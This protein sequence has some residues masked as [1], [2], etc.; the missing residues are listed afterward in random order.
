MTGL[1]Q[2][3]LYLTRSSLLIVLPTFLVIGIGISVLSTTWVLTVLSTV[4]LGVMAIST[5]QAD[6]SSGWQ[7]FSGV[8][9][10]S[11]AAVVGEKYLFY[12]LLS[13]AGLLIGLVVGTA[14]CLLS[15]RGDLNELGLYLT[16]SVSMALLSGG[17]ALPVNILFR[18]EISMLG[19]LLAYPLS[20][21][22]FILLNLLIGQR[23][24]VGIVASVL[25]VI[26][27][28]LSWY[29]TGRMMSRR[30]LT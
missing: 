13:A 23:E 8:L 24:A 30:D 29:L 27:Y 12:L 20:A 9:P 3:D 28:T 15:G 22:V 14:A 17:V 4:M 21:G 11:R 26:L 10:L 18:A 7:Q 1:L 2:K 19:I 25:G 16:I 5:V 6:K